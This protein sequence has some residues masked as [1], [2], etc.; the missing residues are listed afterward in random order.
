M[1]SSFR[2]LMFRGSVWFVVVS[3]LRKFVTTAAFDRSMVG[4]ARF[5]TRARSSSNRRLGGYLFAH[6]LKSIGFHAYL[7]QSI[8]ES[9]KNSWAIACKGEI[10]DVFEFGTV[11]MARGSPE[12]FP[13]GLT[14]VVNVW[15]ALNGKVSEND[16]GFKPCT[17]K[18][19]LMELEGVKREGG[20]VLWI[21]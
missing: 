1:N 4:V 12:V 2:G 19:P 11:K 9:C 14:H 16:D 10:R 21:A 17:T 18:C 15:G 6:L 3:I 8:S 5:H 7:I 13:E 20:F